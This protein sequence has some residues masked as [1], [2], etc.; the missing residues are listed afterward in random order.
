MPFFAANSCSSF[1]SFGRLTL[2]GLLKKLLILA[3]LLFQYLI[4]QCRR[5]HG[6]HKYR[7]ETWLF[8]FHPEPDEHYQYS[9]DG[10]ENTPRDANKSEEALRPGKKERDWSENNDQEFCPKWELEIQAQAL[11]NIEANGS[12]RT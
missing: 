2:Y 8:L 12:I 9:F 5:K 3:M 6:D 1:F 4:G 7:A 10:E 11:I